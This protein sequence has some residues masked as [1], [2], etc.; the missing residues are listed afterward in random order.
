MVIATADVA[1]IGGGA[2]GASITYHVARRGASVVLLEAERLGF[3]SSGALAGM[4][5]GQAEVEE[6]EAMRD[7]MI[8]GREY[9][10]EFA[11]SSTR[12]LTRPRIRVG[13]RVAHGDR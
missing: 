11:V 9:H 5:S 10:K 3:G 12:P 6:S 7:P 2:I 1:V 4:L 13:R 8:R